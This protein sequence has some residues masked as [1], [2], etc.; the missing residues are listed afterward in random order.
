M[1]SD[2]IQILDS[3]LSY[4]YT[5]RLHNIM[6]HNIW[7]SYTATDKEFYLL[8]RDLESRGL[9]EKAVASTSNNPAMNLYKISD[10]GIHIMEAGGIKETNK[11][12]LEKQEKQEIRERMEYEKLSNEIYDLTK[13]VRDYATVKKQAFWGLVLAGLA[14]LIALLTFIFKI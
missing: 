1:E 13:R 10:K 6:A 3:I 11:K 14:V 9:L 5:N 4:F 12:T 7:G 8:I 2:K